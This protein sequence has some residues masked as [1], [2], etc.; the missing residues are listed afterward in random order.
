MWR[1]KDDIKDHFKTFIFGFIF[2]DINNCIQARANYVVALALLSYTE[3]LGAL[4]KGKIGNSS[5]AD[6]EATLKYFPIEYR[7]LKNALVI[8]YFD[9]NGNPLLDKNGN[10]KKEKG[11][12]G[13]FRC[14]LAHE[15]FIKGLGIV[16]NNEN[17]YADPRR[18][19]IE[20]KDIS[21]NEPLYKISHKRFIFY[22]NEYFR[23]FQCA[24]NK[25][26]KNLLDD[27]DADLKSAKKTQGEYLQDSE[28]NSALLKGFYK[29][30]D[31][32][33]SRKI[34]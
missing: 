3:Y 21:P 13:L 19:G 32:Y 17:G 27:F 7:S 1:S 23:D 18:I 22:T 24:V 5:G 14:G 33:S 11:I 2:T 30:L 4:I 16:N 25:I 20:L 12:Y 26:Y 10:P 6:F 8:Q 29:S 31:M 15:Y 28:L 9:K 34:I